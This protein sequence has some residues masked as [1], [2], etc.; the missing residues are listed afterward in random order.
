VHVS[1]RLANT[2]S[3]PG[4]EVVELYISHPGA[5]GAPR[6]ALVGFERVHLP[7]GGF[8]IVS[9][10]LSPRELSIVD[11]NGNRLVPAGPVELW[12]GSGQPATPLTKPTR[13]APN[14]VALKFTVTAS[15][16]LPH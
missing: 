7:A 9:F 10:V 1:A 6:C 5:E 15:T 14:G 3:I 4:D 2:S 11:P 12:L 16:P 13:P 8:Q